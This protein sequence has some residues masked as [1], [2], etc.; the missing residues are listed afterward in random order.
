[1][2]DGGG[3][4]EAAQVHHT[5][6]DSAVAVVVLAVALLLGL[7]RALAARVLHELVDL[8]VAV[9]VDAVAHFGG[10]RVDEVGAGAAVDAV[11][12][13]GGEAVAV[14]VHIAALIDD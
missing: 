2:F 8:A 5:V 13:V 11:A 3:P 12:F 7:G 14:A 10:A 4:A 6:V 9:V 1:H